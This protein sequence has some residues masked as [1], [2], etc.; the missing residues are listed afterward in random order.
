MECAMGGILTRRQLVTAGI[1]T[2]AGAAGVGVGSRYLSLT[3]DHNS[4]LGL[5]ES[6]TYS[7]QRLLTS[8][9]SLAREFPGSKISK[10][11]PTNGPAPIDPAYR[12]MLAN[13]FTD[14]RLK[15]EGLVA[16]PASFSLDDLKRLPADNHITLH[17]CEQG[18]SYIAQWT[19]VRLSHILELVGTRPEARYVMLVPFPN[20]QEHTGIVRLFWD[21][22]DMVEAL[23]PQTMIA[24]GMNGGDLPPDHGAPVRLRLT[25]Q[26]GYKNVKYLRSIML[27]DSMDKF[28]GTRG[29]DREATWYGGI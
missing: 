28:G 8:N 16:R 27:V 25:R 17:A 7:M 2:A 12:N 3:P 9:Q 10:V 11:H 15:V 19:G 4:L 5:G 18:W 14:W 29:G 21:S 24:Y 26:L 23:H 22:V 20:P 1:A 6:F 13:G